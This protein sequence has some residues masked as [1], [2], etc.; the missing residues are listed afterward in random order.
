MH[1]FRRGHFLNVPEWAR[2]LH[3]AIWIEIGFGVGERIPGADFKFRASDVRISTAPFNAAGSA[4]PQKVKALTPQ[5]VQRINEFLL[6]LGDYGEIHLIVQRGELRYI[7]KVESFKVCGDDG[8][9]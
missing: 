4:K 6:A 3:L 9:Q 8:G 5:Q 1:R 2:E 7:N